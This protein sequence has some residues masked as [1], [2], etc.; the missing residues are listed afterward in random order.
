[1]CAL[2]LVQAV[3]SLPSRQVY[4]AQAART[5]CVLQRSRGVCICVCCGGLRGTL[6]VVRWDPAPLYI[7]QGMCLLQGAAV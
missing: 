3:F 2:L 1:M 6:I 7:H 5:A 4:A